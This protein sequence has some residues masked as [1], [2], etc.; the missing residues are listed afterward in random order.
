MADRSR[1]DGWWEASDGKWYPV[2]LLD[3]ALQ[4]WPAAPPLAAERVP[5]ETSIPE[6]LSIAAGAAVLVSAIAY[7]GVALAGLNLV[8][9]IGANVGPSFVDE[10]SVNPTEYGI[11]AV[12]TFLRFLAL[13][14][15][16]AL[17]MVWLF[18]S[19]KALDARGVTGRTWSSGWTIG[20]WF[21]PFANLIIPR[22]VVGELERIAQ[23]PFT[24]TAVG[25]AWKQHR[26]SSMGDLWWLLWVSGNIVATFG[27]LGRI[28]GPDD[29]GRFA[30]LLA[31]TSI[32][33]VMMA[34]G[35]IAL[36]AVIRSMTRL[37]N[38]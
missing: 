9:A 37:A 11:W 23:A 16:A 6:T 36:F 20:G 5:D 1:G 38:A 25:E 14:V 18:R 19:S 3:S 26:R 31:M 17:V 15:A 13:V 29:D 24:D 32:G 27:E 33:Y 10:L 4:E 35:G 8:S 30:A 12:A 21:V 7:A 28:F 22:L 34:A 2:E